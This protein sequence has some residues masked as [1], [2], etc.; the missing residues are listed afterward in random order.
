VSSRVF[1]RVVFP[2]GRDDCKRLALAAKSAAAVSTGFLVNHNRPPSP[3]FSVSVAGKGLSIY[4]SLLESTLVDVHIS[5][6][7]KGA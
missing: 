1:L 3:R 4:V 7:S 2:V 5:V 6:D